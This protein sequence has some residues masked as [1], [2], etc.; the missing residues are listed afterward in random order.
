DAPRA[1]TLA[2]LRGTRDAGFGTQVIGRIVRR[3]AL[4][5][6]RDD[7]PA[8]LNQ[9][10][11]FLANSES[12]EGLLEAGAQINTL[13]TQAPELG[14]Q[15]VVTVIGDAAQLQVVRSGEPLSLLVSHEGVS[16]VDT[17]ARADGG[18]V[19]SVEV[20]AGLSRSEEHTSE[21]QS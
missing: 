10:Y 13:T 20:R 16:L 8:L 9:G 17:T 3:H 18:A 7:L 21:L 11:V 15:T 2:A 12:Q 14:T 4:L 6:Q 19:P 5:Q 1:F